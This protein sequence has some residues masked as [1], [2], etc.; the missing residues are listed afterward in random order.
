[1]NSKERGFIAVVLFGIVIMVFLD[2]FTDSSEGISWGHFIVEGSAGLAAIAG[3][4]FLMKESF[5]VKHSLE[6]E[7]KNFSD[8]KVE[9]E[10]WKV[11]SKKYLEGLSQV[12]DQQLSD[13]KLSVSEKEVAF[14][15]L[16]GLSLKEVAQVR[17]TS[18]KTAR[19][20]SIAVYA[21]SGLTGRSEL[22]AFFLEDLLLPMSQVPAE[23][24]K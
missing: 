23:K 19:A 1:M 17:N 9:A 16:K 21:K 15:L 6:D 22:A 18:E 11:Q 13:W 8:F 5:L 7:R 10:A 12:I 3:L 24:E 14:L 4:F 2:L 20:Q